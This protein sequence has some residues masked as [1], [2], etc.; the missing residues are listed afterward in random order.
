MKK[1]VT[2][3]PKPAATPQP[4]APAG[5]GPD[6]PKI[7]R[8]TDLPGGTRSTEISDRDFCASQAN[9][10]EL[11]DLRRRIERRQQPPEEHKDVIGICS[12]CGWRAN[13]APGSRIVGTPCHVCGSSHGFRAGG[14]LRAA[15]PAEVEE[16][17]RFK[18][19]LDERTLSR[20]RQ[21]QAASDQ[22]ARLGILGAGTP[23]IQ[24]DDTIKTGGGRR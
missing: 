22:R 3:N 23:S 1:A 19:E 9:D 10:A 15:T 21:V 2:T 12:K 4:A 18:A 13:F 20:M 16:F 11:A 14:T 6:K 24:N 17:W 7:L 8:S 5:P